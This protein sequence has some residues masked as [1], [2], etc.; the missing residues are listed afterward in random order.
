MTVRPL[1]PITTRQAFNWIEPLA[2]LGYAARG[3]I[4]LLVGGLA[5]LSALGNGGSTQDPRGA[6]D[7]L[8]QSPGGW[9]ILLV[10]GIGLIGY[11]IWRFVQGVYD[12]DHDG[13][14]AK[15]L[16]K[17]GGKI[18][19]GV[20][21]VTL[22]MW[23]ISRAI[24][25]ASGGSRDGESQ[26]SWTAWLLEQPLGRW[27]VA[28]VGVAIL[29]AAIG[30]FVKGYKE[31]F[32]DHYDTSDDLL[33]KL[34]PVCRFGLM[35]RGVVFALIAS[36]F[37]YAAWSYDPSQA[38]GLTQAFETIRAMAF[39]QILLALTALGMLAYAV[40]SFIEAYYRRIETPATR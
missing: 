11:A 18:V 20:I 33:R 7:T 1:T 37:L 4:Y 16:A 31:K 27:L 12:P 38:G 2:R 6:L 13:S 10:V 25:N 29:C 9:I 26:R 5:L 24:G 8:M 40:Y 15:G 21:H 35:A 28:A 36:F 34:T 14:D 30:Q 22:A 3:V 39:G 32:K 17:R 23:A 19:S